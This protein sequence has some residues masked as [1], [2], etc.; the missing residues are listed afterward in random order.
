MHGI[1]RK[2]VYSGKADIDLHIRLVFGRKGYDKSEKTF[3]LGM[4]NWGTTV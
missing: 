1:L 4:V 2:T 3:N